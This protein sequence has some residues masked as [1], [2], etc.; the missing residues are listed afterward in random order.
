MEYDRGDS[1]PFD[2]KPNGTPIGS[3]LQEKLPT[4]VR[5][6]NWPRHQV[7]VVSLGLDADPAPRRL[8]RQVEAIV[9]PPD[10][11]EIDNYSYNNVEI[12]LK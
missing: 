1:F 11:L 2:F 6:L 4:K 8:N 3:K 7:T 10:L 5:F 9:R 12:L